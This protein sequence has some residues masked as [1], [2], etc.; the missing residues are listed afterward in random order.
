MIFF[1][2]DKFEGLEEALEEEEGVVVLA[3]LFALSEMDNPDYD[4]L[5]PSL[6][7]MPGTKLKRDQPSYSLSPSLTNFSHFF[8]HVNHVL[9]STSSYRARI[10]PE[11]G[12]VSAPETLSRRGFE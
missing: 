3:F 4:F 1:N 10:L 6:K 8:K 2:Q 11:L 5:T 9:A 12:R 7:S